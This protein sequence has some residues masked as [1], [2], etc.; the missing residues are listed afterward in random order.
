M[1]EVRLKRW[2]DSMRTLIIPKP[3]L[4]SLT[5]LASCCYGLTSAFTFQGEE[6]L[7]WTMG[8]AEA[9]GNSMRA[10]GRT[11]GGQGLIHTE[12]A[13]S[14]KLRAT[15]LTPDVIRAS[16]RKDQIRNRLTDDKANALVAEAEAAGDTVVLVEIDPNEGSGVI[17]LEWAAFLREKRSKGL[18]GVVGVNTPKLREAKGLAGVGQRDYDYDVFWMVFPLFD[19]A[20]RQIFSESA[21]EAELVVQIYG[22]EGTVSWVIPESVRA[23]M[24]AITRRR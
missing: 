12:R 5:A 22:K 2:A 13:T 6:F 1:E 11:G 7:T 16:A 15:W 19:E 9:I 18:S 20:G 10:K 4:L 17:P 3:I 21:K 14:Y 23:R 24:K 8:K